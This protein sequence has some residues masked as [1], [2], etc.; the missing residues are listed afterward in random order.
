M[1]PPDT[2]RVRPK[3]DNSSYNLDSLHPHNHIYKTFPLH[4]LPMHDIWIVTTYESNKKLQL[5]VIL[6]ILHQYN[7]NLTQKYYSYFY[8]IFV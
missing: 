1:N 2:I 4:Y 6:S 5:N 7:F 8:F 3:I